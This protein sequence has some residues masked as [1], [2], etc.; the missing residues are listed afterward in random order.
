MLLRIPQSKSVRAIALEVSNSKST[1]QWILCYDLQMYPYK[2]TLLHKLKEDDPDR[3][4]VFSDWFMEKIRHNDN[5]L[6]NLFVSD[7]STLQL[8]GLVNSQNY[9]IW[10]LDNPHVYRETKSFSPKLAIWIAM[11]SRCVIGPYVFRD[12]DGQPCTVTAE[13]YVHMLKTFFLPQL[14]RRRISPEKVFFQQDLATPHTSGNALAFLQPK[15]GERL[16]SKG[17][18]PARSPDL[19]PPDFYLF[20]HLKDLVY[21]DSPKTL[22]ELE[23]RI[24]HHLGQVSVDTLKAVLKNLVRRIQACQRVRGGHFQHLILDK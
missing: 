18:W 3:P 19:A 13:R 12:E 4:L 17:V 6:E 23:A 11:S 9:R 7:E 24:K 5:F 16:I 21:R 15:F 14:R 10:T 20:G 22:G 2:V 8:D 1:V